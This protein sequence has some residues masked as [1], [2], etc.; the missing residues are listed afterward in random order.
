MKSN[1]TV[2]A[3]V[4]T[5]WNVCALLLYISKIK[6][7]RLIIV[8]NN[9]SVTIVNF[10]K[11]CIAGLNVELIDAGSHSEKLLCLLKV[12]SRSTGKNNT[13][14][15]KFTN[16]SHFGQVLQKIGRF[17]RVVFIDDGTTFLNILDDTIEY[18]HG[19]RKIFKQILWPPGFEPRFDCF[20]GVDVAYIS[21]LE[22]IKTKV[23]NSSSS[24]QNFL[25]LF[26]IQ[27]LKEVVDMYLVLDQQISRW[28]DLVDRYD[29]LVLGSSLVEH[30]FLSFADYDEILGQINLKIST[31]TIYKPHP[32]EVKRSSIASAPTW[33]YDSL[34]D[35]PIEVF[36]CYGYPDNLVS[37]GS[38]TSFLLTAEKLNMKNYVFLLESLFCD[39]TYEMLKDKNFPGT[40]FSRINTS[41]F[42][43]L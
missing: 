21:H 8:L 10:L 11:K 24:F 23:D 29:T 39:R 17:N 42:E 27:R 32:G 18:T 12:R 33:V 6:P 20:H 38:T 22:L 4:H 40:E 37:F 19:W 26:S 36:F 41:V 25:V 28:L 15:V 3:H 35:I 30:R 1:Q 2:I 31:K 16:F 7:R 5:N 13:T 14:Y 9:P 34:S 43:S